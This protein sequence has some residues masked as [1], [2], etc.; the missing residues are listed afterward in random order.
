MNPF[1]AWTIPTPNN[2]SG[3]TGTTNSV[4]V[5]E[6]ELAWLLK[7]RQG[8]NEQVLFCW[9]H[10][11]AFFFYFS[12]SLRPRSPSTQLACTASGC[13][14]NLFEFWYNY[15]WSWGS[16]LP[17][18]VPSFHPVGRSVGGVMPECGKESLDVWVGICFRNNYAN[19]RVPTN[20]PRTTYCPDA[21]AT[22]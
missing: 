13:G 15:N 5:G 1:K 3:T 4:V 11:I 14:F 19:Q 20:Q 21:T 22:I 10:K 9:R 16:H 18:C 12:V 17:L 8:K 7:C 6:H 2:V